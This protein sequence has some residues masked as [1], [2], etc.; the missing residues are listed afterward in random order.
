[1]RIMIIWFHIALVRWTAGREKKGRPGKGGGGKCIKKDSINVGNDYIQDE[2]ESGNEETT[3]PPPF[4]SFL[5]IKGTHGMVMYHLLHH[6]RLKA[7]YIN[8]SVPDVIL[9]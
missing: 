9:A 4:P 6:R 7:R 3:P 1:M 2:I 5:P 8:F